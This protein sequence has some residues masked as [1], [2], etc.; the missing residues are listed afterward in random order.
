MIDDDKDDKIKNKA[1]NQAG[2]GAM[3][4]SEDSD[5]DRPGAVPRLAHFAG[6]TVLNMS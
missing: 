3:A 6:G 5:D 4:K 2:F 1:K